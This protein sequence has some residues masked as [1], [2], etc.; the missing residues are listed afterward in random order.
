M[1]D[2]L[3]TSVPVTDTDE[4]IMAPAALKGIAKSAGYSSYAFDLNAE[5]FPLIK[6]HP[7]S[8]KIIDFFMHSNLNS[9]VFDDIIEII[10]LATNRIL[11]FNANIIGLSLLTLYSQ[12]FTYW[13][14]VR[15]K[16][17]SPNTKIVIGGAGIK[18]TLLSS[19]NEFCDDLKN[20]GLID[21]YITGDAELSLVEFLN[22][23]HNF[24]GIDSQSWEEVIDLNKAPTPDYDDYN[25]S[26]YE[27]PGIPIA[28][29]RGC[30]REC[31]FCDII[32]HWKKFRYR[33]AESVFDEMLTQINKYKIYKFNFFNSLTNGNLKEFKKLMYYIAEYNQ[34]KEPQ[35]QISWSGY[36]IIRS[37]SQHTNELWELIAKTN[38]TLLLGVESVVRHVRWGLGK[39]FENE[40]IDFH[41]EMAKQYKIKLI[42]LLIVGYPTET[43][44]DYEFT[45]QWFKDRVEIYGYRDPVIHIGMSFPAILENTQ[46]DRNAEKLNLEK[47][48][49]ITVWFNKETKISPEERVEYYKELYTICKPF[50]PPTGVKLKGY[51]TLEKLIK[52]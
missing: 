1:I 34:D 32:E 48:K 35:Q 4:P 44:A 33:T 28:D 26:L 20:R 11:S 45:K 22:G 6:K 21:H 36:F 24:P 14:C 15:L 3:F 52:E 18:H 23:N 13:L 47:G 46:L 49:Y 19:K 5:I 38:A 37:K 17:L 39:K 51:E 10:D 2:I 8:E 30:V 50:N 41:L 43:R 7:N 9:D 42:L 16:S 31:E 40:D 25:F 12:V 29:S 27:N